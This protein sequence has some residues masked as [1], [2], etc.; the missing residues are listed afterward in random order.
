[1]SSECALSVHRWDNLS[2]QPA[3]HQ[4]APF[5]PRAATEMVVSVPMLDGQCGVILLS[6]WSL[7]AEDTNSTPLLAAAATA[8]CTCKLHTSAYIGRCM[9]WIR[10]RR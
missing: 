8:V 2:E 1:M 6:L 10:R 4:M 9:V 5:L 7:P 3:A